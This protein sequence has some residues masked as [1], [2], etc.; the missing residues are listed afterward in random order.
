MG[1]TALEVPKVSYRSRSIDD[2]RR[3]SILEIRVF[4]EYVVLCQVLARMI[5]VL[6]HDVER[7]A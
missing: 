1:E 6:F 4:N 7:Y 3:F 2:D 5:I